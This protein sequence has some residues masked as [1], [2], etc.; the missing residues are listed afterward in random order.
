MLKNSFAIIIHVDMFMTNTSIYYNTPNKDEYNWFVYYCM[1][2]LYKKD[3][4]NDPR[5][6][7]ITNNPQKQGVSSLFYVHLITIKILKHGAL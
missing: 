6:C 4:L 1:C 5:I 2:F 7:K 3:F